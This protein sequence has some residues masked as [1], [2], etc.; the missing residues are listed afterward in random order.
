MRG[1]GGFLELEFI[2]WISHG[3]GIEDAVYGVPGVATKP[4]WAEDKIA[5]LGLEGGCV[6]PGLARVLR[7]KYAVVPDDQHFFLIV[8]EEGALPDINRGSL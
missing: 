7:R 2:D 5:F 4:V 6:C 8:A 3:R 1:W